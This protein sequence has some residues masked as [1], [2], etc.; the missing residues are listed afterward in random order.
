M[1]LVEPLHVMI[2]AIL[3]DPLHVMN[4]MIVVD[5]LRIILTGHIE[6]AVITLPRTTCLNVAAL[7]MMIII[8]RAL[9]GEGLGLHHR[10][11]Q[12][13]ER[14]NRITGAIRLLE[15]ETLVVGE[16]MTIPL[17]SIGVLLQEKKTLVTEGTIATPLT[18]GVTGVIRTLLH[19]PRKAIVVAV[20]MIAAALTVGVADVIHTLLHLPKKTM[21]VA[22]EMIATVLAV[23]IT[24]HTLLHLL[25]KGTLV[26]RDLIA[27]VPMVGVTESLPHLRKKEFPGAIPQIAEAPAMTKA[28][29]QNL[30]PPIDHRGHP[31]IG[32]VYRALNL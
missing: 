2:M 9:V 22:E 4:T 10:D 26:V 23:G 28:I 25:R 19:L 30:D 7:V 15:K 24:A 32:L 12:T 29:I 11:E 1:I 21:V 27:T 13:R 3:V 31:L 14:V 17:V 8:L 20:E 6:V 18:V 5:P 16:T